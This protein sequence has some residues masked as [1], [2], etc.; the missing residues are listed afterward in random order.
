MV[1]D[2]LYADNGTNLVTF[3]DEDLKIYRT[4]DQDRNVFLSKVVFNIETEK[5]RSRNLQIIG[6]SVVPMTRLD[7][8]GMQTQEQKGCRACHSK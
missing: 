3:W 4:Y 1:P 6:S 2:L 8:Y 5:K 7:N